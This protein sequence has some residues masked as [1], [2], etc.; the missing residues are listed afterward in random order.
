MLLQDQA[1]PQP[2]LVGL[3]S[4]YLSREGAFLM[5]CGDI[6]Y[7]FVGQNVSPEFCSD[8]LDAPDFASIPEGQVSYPSMKMVF[9]KG[10]V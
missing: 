2:N 10:V 8:I 6:M 3:S 4:E 5:D 7:L 9:K 1:I